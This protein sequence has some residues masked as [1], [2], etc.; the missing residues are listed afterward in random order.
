MIDITNKNSFINIKNLIS[1]LK[2][3]K[4]T[5][6][7]L[8]VNKI[9]LVSEKNISENEIP[10]ILK[11]NSSFII[12]EISITNSLNYNTFINELKENLNND[13]TKILTNVILEMP[14]SVKLSLPNLPQ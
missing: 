3:E 7:I 2:F 12:R 9:D 8:L 11:I 14:K 4:Y 10:E 6:T 13:Q 1:R 5:K